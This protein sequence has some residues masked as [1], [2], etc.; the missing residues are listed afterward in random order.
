MYFGITIR[1]Q[2][3]PLFDM[4]G[5]LFGGGGPSNPQPALMKVEPAPPAQADLD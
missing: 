1:S 4:M 3:N 2:T 5:S